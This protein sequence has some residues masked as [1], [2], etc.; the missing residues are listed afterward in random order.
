MAFLLL[1]NLV[2]MCFPEAVFPYGAYND[3]MPKSMSVLE[4]SHKL[5]YD[6]G[7]RW[8][9]DKAHDAVREEVAVFLFWPIR[10][11]CYFWFRFSYVL[12]N[13]FISQY[14]CKLK[15]CQCCI[16]LKKKVLV[17]YLFPCRERWIEDHYNLSSTSAFCSLWI[18]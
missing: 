16:F 17:F 3:A 15:L 10:I 11:C 14:F 5:R 13:K 1:V 2:N 9:P 8:N 6:F 7:T 4:V 18:L 12:R